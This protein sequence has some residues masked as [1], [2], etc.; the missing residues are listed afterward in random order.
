MQIGVPGLGLAAVEMALLAKQTDQP[1]APLISVELI[2]GDD[3][4]HTGL[5]VVGVRTAERRHVDVL[6]GD[7]AHDVGTGDEHAALRCHHDD[8]RQRRP[9]A[10]PP[11]AKPTTTEICGM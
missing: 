9:V 8:V 1:T 7:T 5:L 6:T 4:A 10:A 11:A 3:V 2:V